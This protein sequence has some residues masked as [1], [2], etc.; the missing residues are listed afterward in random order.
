MPLFMAF[1]PSLVPVIGSF[2][3]PRKM[4]PAASTLMF[5]RP[6]TFTLSMCV[7]SLAH[8]PLPRLSRYTELLVFTTPMTLAMTF[9]V[10]HGEPPPLVYGLLPS[11]VRLGPIS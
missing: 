10:P 3:S 4:E 5:I 2:M 11:T 9:D 7:V 1:G 6:M 8:Q